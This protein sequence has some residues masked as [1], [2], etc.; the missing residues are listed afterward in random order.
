MFR[1]ETTAGAVYLKACGPSQA[2]EPALTVRLAREGGAIVPTPLA[3][4]SRE[5]WMLLAEGGAK[6]RERFDGPALL[7]AWTRILPRYAELQRRFLGHDDELL[8]T[9]LPDR[10]LEGLASQLEKMLDDERV[11]LVPGALS[12]ADPAAL[13]RLL[14]TFAA[15]C[16]ELA[17]LGIGAT[18][19]HDDLH[20][21]NVLVGRDE[22]VFDWGDACLTHPFLTLCVTL[23]FAAQHA[24]L[25]TGD[26]AIARL[27][28]AY[29]EPW[30]D[31]APPGALREA[32]ELAR[33]LGGAT[34]ALCWYRVVTLIGGSLD[35]EDG[36]L[37]E[38]VEL[39]A[40]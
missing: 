17:S 13:R 38:L 8:A 28:D 15:R 37:Q 11:A 9:G 10:R 3:V 29:L 33:V 26:P 32:A 19:Q 27:R 23:R 1:A 2:H 4:H 25:A 30:S 12:G 6:L 22:V 31:L 39:L 14:P 5:P 18:A 36:W 40:R 16:N 34:R 7:D 21:W 35:D 24:G 20:D